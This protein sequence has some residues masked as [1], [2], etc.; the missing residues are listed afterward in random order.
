MSDPAWA[1]KDVYDLSDGV[2]YI[3]DAGAVAA[4]TSADEVGH[5]TNYESSHDPETAERAYLNLSD[6]QVDVTRYTHSGSFTLMI[7]VGANAMRTKIRNAIKNK[8]KLKITLV[9]GGDTNGEI[10]VFD[11]CVMGMTKSG[12]EDGWTLEC[13]FAAGSYSGTEAT[14]PA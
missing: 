5:V 14:D 1:A 12:E 9:L 7:A 4:V 2:L 3:Q 13:T 6:T 11:R 10:D 8:E